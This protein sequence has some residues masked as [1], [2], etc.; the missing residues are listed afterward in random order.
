MACRRAG[1]ASAAEAAEA[2]SVNTRLVR[3]IA[4][5]R[6]TATRRCQSS[7]SRDRTNR[8][9]ATPPANG[10]RKGLFLLLASLNERA[11]LLEHGPTTPEQEGVHQ[12]LHRRDR[13]R[14][15]RSTAP[16]RRA[17]RD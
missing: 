17:C 8:D 5:Q 9:R 15:R 6:I 7:L 13:L 14:H 2:V 11:N 1:A 10:E 4:L 16:R 3:F 12:R